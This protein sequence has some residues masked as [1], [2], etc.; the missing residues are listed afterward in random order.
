MPRLPPRGAAEAAVALAQRERAAGGER[1]EVFQALVLR[2]E[3]VFHGAG[4]DEGGVDRRIGR[5]RKLVDPR[6]PDAVAAFDRLPLGQ[7]QHRPALA[8][9][10]ALVIGGRRAPA[11]VQG[12]GRAP[13]EERVEDTDRVRVVEN[14]GR[15]PRPRFDAHGRR[16]ELAHAARVGED[17]GQFGGCEVEERRLLVRFP[18]AHDGRSDRWR[19]GYCGQG[20]EGQGGPHRGG[21]SGRALERGAVPGRCARTHAHSPPMRASRSAAAARPPRPARRRPARAQ[22]RARAPRAASAAG[23]SPPAASSTAPVDAFTLSAGA[24]APPAV[25]VVDLPPAARDASLAALLRFALPMTA[26][27]VIGP[28]LGLIDSSVVGTRSSLEL[29]ALGPATVVCD[30]GEGG[31]RGGLRVRLGGRQSRESASKDAQKNSTPA[32]PSRA[33]APATTPSAPQAPTS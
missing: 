23:D 28:V 6:F 17:R 22:R 18:V 20:G 21:R 9:R 15:P 11:A 3:L 1:D 8:P 14:D 31:S 4:T 30:Y 26:I 7:R 25:T 29:A 2:V 32:P 24:D 13:G 10:D 16:L 5:E 19:G 27:W 12:A 33:D